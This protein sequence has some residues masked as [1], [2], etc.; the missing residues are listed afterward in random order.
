M[1]VHPTFYV[2]RLKPYV[3]ATIPAPEAESP[4]PVRT[5]SRHATDADTESTRALA[6]GVR[7]SPSVARRTRQTPSDGASPSCRAAPAP[8]ESQQSLPP[9]HARAQP[10]RGSEP[11]LRRPSPGQ[12]P[13]P[14]PSI[15]EALGA[16][17]RRP[18][19][20][21]AAL[22]QP[23]TSAIAPRRLRMH[24]GRGDM[25]WS[26]WLITI[27]VPTARVPLAV[28]LVLRIRAPLD[29]RPPR[30]TIGCAG[31]DTRRHR[32]L[33]E[34]VPDLVSDFEASLARLTTSAA[35]TCCNFK[36]SAARSQRR[37]SLLSAQLINWRSPSSRV[38]LGRSWHLVHVAHTPLALHTR[39]RMSPI[40]RVLRVASR[41]SSHDVKDRPLRPAA[42]QRWMKAHHERCS[43]SCV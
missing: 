41:S 22:Q 25:S 12:S 32:I 27:L 1:R 31:L 4:Q 18:A 43:A 9:Q 40:E 37:S 38:G 19:Q 36:I 34:D 17:R 26:A 23:R 15:A 20:S 21:Q 35:T 24:R 6:P 11:P 39:V 28:P 42:F 10:Q 29:G 2:G 5:R 7:P 8:I 30:S 16:P 33:L 14:S 3:P 13:A